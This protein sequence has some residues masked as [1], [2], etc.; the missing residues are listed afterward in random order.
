MLQLSA[1][2]DPY[3]TMLLKLYNWFV[4]MMECGRLVYRVPVIIFRAIHRELYPPNKKSVDGQVV[5]ITG[6]AHGL[7]REMAFIF[8]GLGA[9]VVLWDI[10]RKNLNQ[11]VHMIQSQGGQVHGYEVDVAECSAVLTVGE[12]V[13]K[14][15]GQVDILINNAAICTV[16]PF[17]R[18]SGNEVKRSIAVNL[19]SHM[20]TIRCFLPA[21]TRRRKGHI[22]A[23]SSTLGLTGKSH[24]PDYCAAKFGVNGLM[25]SLEA[26]LFEQDSKFIMTTTVCPAA[27]DTGLVRCIET[28]LP[29]LFPLLTPTDAAHKIVDAIRRNEKQVIIP[30]AYRFLFAFLRNCPQIVC[31]YFADFIGNTTQI[32]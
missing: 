6:A 2:I 24:F 3:N 17:S 1:S 9:K 19:L 8:A 7:G 23:I 22:V 12:R 25:Q 4:I 16:Q 14:E 29:F 13:Q 11:T 26:E 28:R 20:W 21:M 18:L 5:L 31:H 10:N 30:P 32:S 27:I 15:V